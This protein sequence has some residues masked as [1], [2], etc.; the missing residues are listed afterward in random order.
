MDAPLAQAESKARGRLRP[1]LLRTLVVEPPSEHV[2]RL[3]GTAVGLTGAGVVDALVMAS[4]S[5]RGGLVY[6]SDSGDLERLTEVF[7]NVG[8][9]SI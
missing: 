7:R 2:A 8:V 3:A 9:E 6:T 4:A 1:Q 5:L